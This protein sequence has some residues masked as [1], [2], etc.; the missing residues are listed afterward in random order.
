MGED[1]K[2]RLCAAGIAAVLV[3]SAQPAFAVDQVHD[4]IQVY[5]ADIAEVGQ[6]TYEQHFNYAAVDRPPR[7]SRADL[8]PTTA[9]RARRNLPTA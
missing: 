4:E 1:L 6:F 7:N 2:L 5:N 3:V 8:P 9:C